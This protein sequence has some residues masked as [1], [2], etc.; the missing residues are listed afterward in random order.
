MASIY[1]KKFKTQITYQ[2]KIRRAGIRPINKSFL[3]RT[4]E[5]RWARSMETKLDKG[6]YSDYTEASKLTIDVIF[7]CILLHFL[8]AGDKFSKKTFS[9]CAINSNKSLHVTN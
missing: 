3:T 5:K 9:M 1:R 4:E 7:S 8:A 2:V 6:D